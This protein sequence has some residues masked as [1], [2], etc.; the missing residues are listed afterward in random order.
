MNADIVKLTLR[1]LT[2]RRRTAFMVLVALLPAALAV[3]FRAGGEAGPA[4]WTSTRLLGGM[5]V[6]MLLPLA[7]LVFGTAILGSEV[8]D[9][10]AV[11]LLA[12]PIPRREILLS[13]LGVAWLLTAAYVVP[14][15]AIGGAIA[16]QGAEGWGP[17][18]AG[19]V[20]AILAGSLAYCTVFAFLSL[21]TGRAFIAGLLYVFIW[22]GL[23]T[24][25]FA[26]TRLLSIR[27]AT[28]GLA[29]FVGDASPDVFDPD[30][31]GPTAV[32]ILALATAVAGWLAVRKLQRFEIGESG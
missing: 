16:F 14:S 21:L 19:F 1:Q 23:V 11:Y 20:V 5:V 8:E 25:L 12:R 7:S 2:G 26:G 24:G 28:L 10:T 29:G 22:E 18:L 6:T 17:M 32:F 3:A 31:G 9:G 27:H 15:A 13:K 4:E 30:L